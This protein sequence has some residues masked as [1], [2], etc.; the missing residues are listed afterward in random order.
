M[1]ARVGFKDTFFI[2][3]LAVQSLIRLKKSIFLSNVTGGRKVP[4]MGHVLF[5]WALN[6][7]VKNV[8][9]DKKY[10][11]EKE[12]LKKQKYLLHLWEKC[13]LIIYKM[14]TVANWKSLLQFC[15]ICFPNNVKA[16]HS[17]YSTSHVRNRLVA[18]SHIIC[19]LYRFPSLLAGPG[20]RFC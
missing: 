13:N 2:N 3:Y 12:R 8:F 1:R 9:I 6:I 11:K 10:Q 16:L 19:E 17:G 14:S 7:K 15:K 20:L 4:K 18:T 5:E